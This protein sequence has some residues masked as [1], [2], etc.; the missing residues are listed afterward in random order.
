MTWNM[1]SYTSINIDPSCNLYSAVDSGSDSSWFF[2]SILEGIFP[3]KSSFY[4]LISGIRARVRHI[5][6]IH[7]MVVAAAEFCLCRSTVAAAPNF[8]KSVCRADVICVRICV[9]DGFF[10]RLISGCARSSSTPVLS[11]SV[12]NPV[13]SP[14][15]L[16]SCASDVYWF[17]VVGA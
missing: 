17:C 4:F 7:I 10:P 14:A 6:F 8:N 16:H 11:L 15:H 2:S 13:E 12:R 9:V 1:L 5:V 3:R